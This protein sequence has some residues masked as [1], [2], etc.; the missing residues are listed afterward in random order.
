MSSNPAHAFDEDEGSDLQ[1]VA[2]S[3][4]VRGELTSHLANM[5]QHPFDEVA[6]KR[7][8]GF[9]GSKRLASGSAAAARLQ[10]GA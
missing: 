7:L 9:L 10:R 4:A 6:Q 3:F 8:L 1:D 2:T 5:H